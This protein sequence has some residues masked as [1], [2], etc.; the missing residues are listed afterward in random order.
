[1]KTIMRYLLLAVIFFTVVSSSTADD[2]PETGSEGTGDN[3]NLAIVTE[4]PS[5]EM[6][7]VMME[8]EEGI[9]NQESPSQVLGDIEHLINDEGLGCHETVDEDNRLIIKCD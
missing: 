7:E 2:V 8:I 4:S 5:E 1:M 6:E 3:E 9:H